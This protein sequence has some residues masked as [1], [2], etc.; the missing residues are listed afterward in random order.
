MARRRKLTG[1]PLLIA[2]AGAALVVGCGR[3]TPVAP[4][5]NLVVPPPRP[6]QVCIVTVPPDASVTIDGVATT[7]QCTATQSRST[8]TVAVSAPGYDPQ[9]VEVSMMADTAASTEVK[10]TLE[11]TKLKP[12]PP[13]GNLVAPPP[14][15]DGP[16]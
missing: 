4:V 15:E 14:R 9:T 5:G 8:V 3:L 6:E 13:V 2:S 10:V 1:R 11:A 7:T 12:M 16:Q